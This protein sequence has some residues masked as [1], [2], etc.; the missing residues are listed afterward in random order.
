MMSPSPSEGK[1]QLVKKQ[2]EFTRSSDYSP[3]FYNASRI[4]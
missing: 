1:R 4:Q 3:H 2:S